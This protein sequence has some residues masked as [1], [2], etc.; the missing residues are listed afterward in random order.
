MHRLSGLWPQLVQFDNLWLAWRRARKGK[1]R[2]P[3]VVLFELEVECHLR[4]LQRELVNGQ[5]QP[6]AYRLFSL[7]ERKPR[8]IAAA[9]FRDRV[10][11]HALMNIIEAP[12]DRRFIDD[13]YACRRGKGTHA[14][15][16]RYQRWSQR[17]RYVLQ[18]D[19][20][21]YFPSI[22]HTLLKTALRAR[23][24]DQPVLDLLD[25]I[26]DASPSTG[27]LGIPIGNLT[28]QFFANLYLDDFDHWVK[29]KLRVKP[30][31]RYVDDMVFLAHDKGQLRAILPLIEAQLIR[32]QVRI[33]PNKVHI[34]PTRCGINFLGY[35]ITPQCRRLANGNGYRFRRRLRTYAHLYRLG[36]LD[37]AAIDPAV[38]AWIGHACHGDTIGLRQTLFGHVSFVRGSLPK[39][40]SSRSRRL[41]EQ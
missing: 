37:W 11:H 36:L 33:H 20:Q 24:K 25:Q 35:Q 13:S 1:S 5:Y 16:E 4:Q 6:G 15:I 28:S 26:I 34:R 22:Q 21:R 41:V 7:Y 10:V 18:L 39:A 27:G 23:I 8:I 3:D 38:Q 2:R 32:Y 14:A 19:L 12:L 31:L 9:P 40:K 30:Y 17:Y 29:E